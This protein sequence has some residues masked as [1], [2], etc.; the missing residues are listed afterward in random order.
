MKN[1]ATSCFDES[2]HETLKV[3]QPFVPFCPPSTTLTPSPNCVALD[4]HEHKSAGSVAFG[5][6]ADVFELQENDLTNL[7]I[8]GS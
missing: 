2:V 7:T 5:L 8:A 6:L 4:L 1:F 3:G